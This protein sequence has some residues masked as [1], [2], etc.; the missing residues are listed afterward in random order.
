[1]DRTVA[2]VSQLAKVTI[3]KTP[4]AVHALVRYCQATTWTDWPDHIR[5]NSRD[6]MKDILARVFDTRTGG[7][8]PGD[9]FII[10]HSHWGRKH[11]CALALSAHAGNSTKQYLNCVIVLLA[12]LRET[13][14]QEYLAIVREHLKH[15]D[16]HVE[17]HFSDKPPAERDQAHREYTA[18]RDALCDGVLHASGLLHLGSHARAVPTK[19]VKR[20]LR[21]LLCGTSVETKDTLLLIKKFKL[22]PMLKC[23]HLPN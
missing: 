15:G 13:D 12:A 23:G 6:W 4:K 3:D 8:V 18:W 14:R 5:A 9:L 11:G 20:C 21:G 22:E 1:M 19:D 2:E 10:D 16:V 7:V 17:R